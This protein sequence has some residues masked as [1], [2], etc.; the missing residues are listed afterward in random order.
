MPEW[1]EEWFG[2]EYLRL[3]PH[4]DDVDADRA[5][6]LLRRAVP[7][8]AGLRVLDIGAG[9]GRHARA[10]V[11]AGAKC[12][13]LDLSAALL[14]RARQATTAPLVRADMRRLPF[15]PRSF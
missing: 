8:R 15:R 14:R 13:G 5:V 12:V 6:G 9:A 4:R 10:I 3:Y 2:E 1:F 11:A 7:W